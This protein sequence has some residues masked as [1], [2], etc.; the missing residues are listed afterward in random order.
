MSHEQPSSQPCAAPVALRLMFAATRG[1]ALLLGAF[2]LLNVLGELR[3][4][5]FDAN[6]WWIDLRFANA[7]LV[8]ATMLVTG[9]LLVAFGVRLAF[10]PLRGLG[11]RS[12]LGWLILVAAFNSWTFLRL[13]STGEIRSGFPLPLSGAM[14]IVLTAIAWAVGHRELAR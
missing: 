14:L 11:L 4:P 8:R 10:A 9:L 3:N 5:G 7:L 6:L 1:V 13:V 12:W 2:T